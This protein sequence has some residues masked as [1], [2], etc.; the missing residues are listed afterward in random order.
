MK[1]VPTPRLDVGENALVAQLLREYYMVKLYATHSE[2]KTTH[3]TR[4][5]KL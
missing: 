2:G 5:N 1:A 3:M 4:G